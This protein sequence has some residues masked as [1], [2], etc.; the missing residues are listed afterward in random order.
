M[1]RRTSL[2]PSL[3]RLVRRPRG[4]GRR[5]PLALQTPHRAAV[6]WRSAQELPRPRTVGCA[7]E[8]GVAGDQALKPRALKKSPAEVI[9]DH[10]PAYQSPG[11][12]PDASLPALTTTSMGV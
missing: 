9:A 3:R 11:S 12:T 4:E 10:P 6:G 2:S 7:E 1:R 8:A 5:R